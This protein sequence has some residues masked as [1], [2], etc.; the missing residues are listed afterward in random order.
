MEKENGGMPAANYPALQMDSQ[1]DPTLFMAVYAGPDVMNHSPVPGM[2]AI[3]MMN[4]MM[5]SQKPSVVPCVS[6][7]RDVPADGSFCPYCGERQPKRRFCA[8]CGAVLRDTD[9]FCTECGAKI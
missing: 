7:G 6:C 8:Q 1:M 3:R 2:M 5:N 9:K 4:G